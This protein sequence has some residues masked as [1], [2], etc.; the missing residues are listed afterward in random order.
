MKLDKYKNMKVSF[1]DKALWYAY[2]VGAINRIKGTDL[3]KVLE[4]HNQLDSIMLQ[5]GYQNIPIYMQNKD[6]IELIKFCESSQD[7][8]KA[9]NH[10][11]IF[12]TVN[13]VGI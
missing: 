4:I 3:W 8:Q 13:E 9:F 10:S 6:L 5:L 7:F 11:R 2:L 12:P 1:Q